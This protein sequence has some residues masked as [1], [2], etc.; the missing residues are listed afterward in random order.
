MFTP[1]INFISQIAFRRQVFRPAQVMAVLLACTAGGSAVAA[2][3]PHAVSPAL[4]RMSVSVG[5]F[6]ADTNFQLGVNTNSGRYETPSYDGERVTIPRV[7]A[8][9]LLG[10]SQ[11]ISLDYYRY[12]KSYS[13][14][15]NGSTTL[16]GQ[17]LSGTAALAAN[18]R[19]EIGQA[20]YKWWIGEGADVVGVGL[21][22]AYYRARVGGTVSGTVSGSGAGTIA[23]ADNSATD[24]FERSTFAPLLELGW[25]HSFSPST[26]MFAEA[27]GIKKNGGSINGHIYTATIGAEWFPVENIG[28]VADYGISRISL[29]RDLGR[30]DSAQLNLRLNGPSL[31]VKA[32]F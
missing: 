25:R 17:P 15:L 23:G 10:R 32:R 24:A 3:G 7:K 20:A 28:I 26:R 4:D 6:S 12:D 9:F 31:Y 29:T 2:D 1:S 8:D 21:G 27:S 11:G 22:A 13:S 30:E 16:N 19:L 14:N 18:A 5:A